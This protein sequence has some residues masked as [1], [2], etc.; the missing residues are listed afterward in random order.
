M[1]LSDLWI[2]PCAPGASLGHCGRS[3]TRCLCWL[4][5]HALPCLWLLRSLRSA[6]LLSDPYVAVSQVQFCG[7][8]SGLL[9]DSVEELQ[10]H[11]GP[12]PRIPSL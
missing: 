2:Q 7:Y 1:E 10:K 11:V 6:P 9:M 12:G 4:R 8:Q 3:I 5:A